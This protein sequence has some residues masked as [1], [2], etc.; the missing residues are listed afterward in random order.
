MNKIEFSTV[1]SYIEGYCI[2]NLGKEK[3]NFI[4]FQI[5]DKKIN[6]QISQTIEFTDI[7]KS[8]D[9]PPILIYD[10]RN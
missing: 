9:F 4:T 8:D 5:D 7:I 2:S 1:R 6:E 10:L 3:L